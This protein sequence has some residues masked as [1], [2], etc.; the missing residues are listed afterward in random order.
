MSAPAANDLRRAKRIACWGGVAVAVIAEAVLIPVKWHG[1]LPARMTW[2]RVI[3]GPAFMAALA[4]LV[5]FTEGKPKKTLLWFF[6]LIL[7]ATALMLLDPAPP[8]CD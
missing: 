7:L 2:S 4:P 5:V 8:G 1:L 3:L 6:I